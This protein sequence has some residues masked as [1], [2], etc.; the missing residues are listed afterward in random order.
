MQS[1]LAVIQ[2][3][4]CVLCGWRFL[5]HF[6]VVT[7]TPYSCVTVGYSE[8]YFVRCCALKRTGKYASESKVMCNYIL[9]DFKM[10]CFDVSFLTS[11]RVNNFFETEN[12]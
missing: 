6:D 5:N 7:E 8:L 11:I 1:T 12:F 2:L 4:F 10:R 3:E 9:T